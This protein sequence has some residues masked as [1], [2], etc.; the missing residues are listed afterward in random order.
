[1][2]LLKYGMITAGSLL[3][4]S[5][6]PVK[7][8]PIAKF[9]ITNNQQAVGMGRAR[10]AQSLLITTPTA[11]SGY[12]T[13]KM[14]YV[15]T[16]HRL[17]TF[18]KNKWVASPAKL[19]LPIIESAI[20]NSHYFYAIVTPPFSGNTTYRLDTKLIALQQ[21]FIRPDSQVRLI[22]KATLIRNSNNHV[23][24]TRTY[25]MLT[26]AE[27]NAPYGGVLATSR[28]ANAIA[29]KI[30]SMVS[31]YAKPPVKHKDPFAH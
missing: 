7:L 18:T 12:K 8:P 14:I 19:L 9:S 17:Q 20:R 22:L 24:A 11:E 6:S 29:R 13:D 27:S 16:P 25:K 2:K 5:C 15:R 10:T 26:T 3:L 1:M 30:A 31:R 4:I 23:L 28:S 21:E